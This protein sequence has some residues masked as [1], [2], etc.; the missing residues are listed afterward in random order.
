MS[1]DEIHD[2]D[3]SP[4]P[5]AAGD[6]AAGASTTSYFTEYF[7]GWITDPEAPGGLVIEHEGQR[8]PLLGEACE[9]RIS[10]PNFGH[11]TTHGGDQFLEGIALNARRLQ[12]HYAE[13]LLEAHQRDDLDL[14]DIA[15]KWRENNGQSEYQHSLV[16]AL[17]GIK[18]PEVRPKAY[19][20]PYSE[21]PEP[22]SGPVLW[23]TDE[24]APVSEEDIITVHNVGPVIFD[25]WCKSTGQQSAAAAEGAATDGATVGQSDA[26][27]SATGLTQPE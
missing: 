8:Q 2:Q 16:N 25:L 10:P 5:T 18:P 19:S 22:E 4:G 14:L 12:E 15:H 17:Q 13:K 21:E 26:G 6:D 7:G 3:S 9:A 27:G 24:V 1:N 11:E 20:L 23:W